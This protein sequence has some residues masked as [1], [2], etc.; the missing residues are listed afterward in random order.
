MTT[1]ADAAHKGSGDAREPIRSFH[2]ERPLRRGRKW[3]EHTHVLL[4]VQACRGSPAAD[5]KPLLPV[6]NA[7]QLL[8]L[9]PD[10]PSPGIGT[11]CSA[12]SAHAHVPCY[13]CNLQRPQSQ[14]GGAHDMTS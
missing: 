14:K 7:A 9:H 13:C 2:T 3:A 5:A 6:K 8:L 11:A 1:T 4:I 10:G 12:P